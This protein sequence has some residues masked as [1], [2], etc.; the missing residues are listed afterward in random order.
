MRLNIKQHR[1]NSTVLAHICRST[2]YT[3][4]S[5]LVIVR[6]GPHK[7]RVDFLVTEA[8]RCGAE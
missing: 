8:A 6:C 1:V 5:L 7:V 2:L 3:H 4:N